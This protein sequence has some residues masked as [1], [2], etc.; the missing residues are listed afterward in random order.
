MTLVK[1][2]PAAPRSRVKHSTT[3]SLRSLKGLQ[4]RLS[5]LRYT[6][7]PEDCFIFTNSADPDQI[8]HSVAFYPDLNCLPK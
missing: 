7:A 5:K 3:E 2:D 8:P 6:L 4:V 1:L